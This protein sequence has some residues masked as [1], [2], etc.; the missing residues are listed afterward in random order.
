M[1]APDSSTGSTQ[2]TSSSSRPQTVT[3]VL[4][5]ELGARH[6][7]G[8]LQ[9]IR[10][11]KRVLRSHHRT[12]QRLKRYGVDGLA[13]AVSHIADLTEELASLRQ[14]E[15]ERAEA[16]RGALDHLL[17]TVEHA[18]ERVRQ[19]QSDP[20]AAAS[21]PADKHGV[22]RQEDAYVL[23]DAL[24]N[25]VQE[26]RLELWTHDPSS[27]DETADADALLTKLRDTL[28]DVFSAGPDAPPKP[29]APTDEVERLRS[30][31]GR[32]QARIDELEAALS[33]QRSD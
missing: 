2:Q 16:R 21:P 26:L 28:D 27:V 12:Q 32:Q 5:R 9:Q 19:L 23:L 33:A 18:R 30:I 4:C 22:E 6:P 11:M 15:R 13:D 1:S 8:A 29:E 31:I 14:R 25:V 20:D 3:E 10:T 24:E 7:D 17:R